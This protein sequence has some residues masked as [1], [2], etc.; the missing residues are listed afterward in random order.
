[1][2]EDSLLDVFVNIGQRGLVETKKAID[3]FAENAKKAFGEA[4][5]YQAKSAKKAADAQIV[6]AKRASAAVAKEAAK[7]A[8]ASLTESQR[9][10]NSL[11]EELL[12]FQRDKNDIAV[13]VRLVADAD[14]SRQFADI[15]SQVAAEQKRFAL[16]E[17]GQGGDASRAAALSTITDL[18]ERDLAALNKQ[19]IAEATLK[20]LDAGGEVKA[21]SLRAAAASADKLALSLKRVNSIVADSKSPQ[22]KAQFRDVNQQVD[23]LKQKLRSSLAVGDLV[24][25]KEALGD[26]RLLLPEIN[27]IKKAAQ[28]Q[29]P[30]NID[31]KKL[32]AQFDN[33]RKQ[34]ASLRKLLA[35]TTTG[36]LGIESKLE[37]AGVDKDIRDIV[38]QFEKL[39]KITDKT[40]NDFADMRNLVEQFGAKTAQVDAIHDS[41]SK[42]A[43]ST[44]QL[45]N[46]AYQVG[47]AFEDAAVGFSLNGLTG[48][49]RGAANNVNF[50]VNNLAQ[51]G[52]LTKALGEKTAQMLPLYL[53]IGTA[54]LFIVPAIW[55][56]FKALEDVDKKSLDLS[57]RFSTEFSDIKFQVSLI[58][59]AQESVRAVREAENA[60]D[61]IEEVIKQANEGEK[62]KFKLTSEI[63]RQSQSK[64]IH[65]FENVA[66]KIG[67]SLKERLEQVSKN[68]ILPSTGQG[69]PG[70]I[71]KADQKEIQHVKNLESALE[72]FRI[73][74]QQV[75]DNSK[76]GIVDPGALQ[77]A[78]D[79]LL[80][81]IDNYKQVIASGTLTEKEF[82]E[83]K[84]SLEAA[85]EAFK[86]L[87]EEAQ[88]LQQ[89]TDSLLG[90]V[91]LEA[92]DATKALTRE[93]QFQKAINEGR[94]SVED[95]ILF[96]MQ[97]QEIAVKK[98]NDELLRLSGNSPLAQQV[99]A[100]NELLLQEQQR[101]DLTKEVRRIEEEIADKRAS[102]A[103]AAESAAERRIKAEDRL[104][105]GQID[106][107]KKVADAQENLQ[108]A[109]R[110]QAQNA[111]DQL[112]QDQ[113]DALQ[114]LPDQVSSQQSQ[115]GDIGKVVIGEGTQAKQEQIKA[116]QEQ[117]DRARDLRRTIEEG[118]RIAELRQR[119]IDASQE[120]Q[121]KIE[122]LQAELADAR[123]R[124]IE[125]VNEAAREINDL[126]AEVKK[127][128]EAIIENNRGL[129]TTLP[130]N[131]DLS[132][133]VGQLPFFNKNEPQFAPEGGPE[134]G[135]AIAAANARAM[136]NTDFT[137]TTIQTLIAT[138][139]ELLGRMNENVTK[140]DASSRYA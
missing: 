11:R 76:Q 51:A 123:E 96:T 61:A 82:E 29:I 26:I 85:Q 12:K 65:D 78:S 44:N 121:D 99:A 109:L 105:K 32:S 72:T 89:I 3:D 129:S 58:I 117:L 55:E 31:T 13:G 68:L 94:L 39:N 34:Y 6:A 91:L 69:D 97:E 64:V 74:Q 77:T 137:S 70:T 56:W 104:A 131:I 52:S 139:N 134:F 75:F 35:F 106:S 63:D 108:D 45:S 18:R 81:I 59:D 10:F 115:L 25:A 50:L 66:D 113:I 124:E 127:L 40:A 17:P 57:E 48:A 86:G 84:A 62:L 54:A 125:S 110:K 22:L 112:I 118:Q 90:P 87:S 41:V 114:A 138:S 122:E 8:K 93:Y 133:P 4:S 43:R 53:G 135:N 19:I 49:V 47:Q 46:N 130:G 67:E 132:Q 60:T 7:A 36:A 95:R 1:M 5:D 100:Q 20:G 140:I 9:Q 116:L 101:I 14:I 98:Q 16:A 33:V 2:P 80:L 21:A 120:A 103:K 15:Q 136:D 73:A 30:L 27:R 28:Q 88:K 37:L 107:Q 42:A 102:A 128:R 92:V 111:S 119:I 24:G 83:A 126:N 23:I 38:I 79:S 71:I